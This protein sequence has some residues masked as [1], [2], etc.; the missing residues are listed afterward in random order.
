M[1]ADRA[2][3]EPASLVP[4]QSRAAPA[5]R[6]TGQSEP[7]PGVE[8]GKLPLQGAAG[9]RP[10][11]HE[12]AREDLNL[13]D[14]AAT[15]S[16]GLRVYQFRHERTRASGRPR[17][18]YLL[19]TREPLCLVSYRGMAGDP[20]FEPG[21]PD[22]ESGV[23]PV[24]PVSIEYGR[25]DSN[26]HLAELESAVSAVGLRPRTPPESRTPFPGV[27]ARCITRHACGAWSER[28]DLNQ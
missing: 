4:G 21:L 16:S 14:L 19:L 11:R 20:G 25:R 8:P 2:G 28:L 1:G 18:A 6:A 22:P 9:R 12:C 17:T 10:G 15:G 3:V 5:D 27:R 7:S 23:L 13:H 24:T 26:A